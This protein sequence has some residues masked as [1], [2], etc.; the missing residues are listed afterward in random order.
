MLPYLE[1]VGAFAGDSGRGAAAGEL[2]RVWR[3]LREQA[4][5]GVGEHPVRIF[6]NHYPRPDLPGRCVTLDV[7]VHTLPDPYL[8]GDRAWLQ[9]NRTRLQRSEEIEGVLFEV[10]KTFQLEGG[11]PRLIEAGIEATTRI[12]HFAPRRREGW[13]SDRRVARIVSDGLDGM[14][15]MIY[16]GGKRVGMVWCDRSFGQGEPDPWAVAYRRRRQE[17][18]AGGSLERLLGFA[19]RF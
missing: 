5:G 3:R 12:Q 18:L 6:V 2:A 11:A 7:V 8:E 14:H 13:F 19:A 4:R 1:A 16:G 15:F 10:R 17:A 9:S